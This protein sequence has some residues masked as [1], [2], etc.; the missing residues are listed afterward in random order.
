MVYL[1]RKENE[2]ISAFVRRFMLRTQSSGI[3]KEAKEKKFFRRPVSRTLRRSHA[4]ERTEKRR[5]F[6]KLKKLGRLKQKQ[7]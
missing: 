4:L 1:T 2:T 7:R 3:L 5:E 6:A